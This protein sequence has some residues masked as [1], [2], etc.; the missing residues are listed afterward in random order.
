MNR[1]TL[2]LLL[3]WLVVNNLHELLPP[4]PAHP[5]IGRGNRRILIDP[6]AYYNNDRHTYNAYIDSIRRIFFYECPKAHAYGNADGLHLSPEA[7]VI[8]KLII[9]NNFDTTVDYKDLY[10]FANL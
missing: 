5:V 9:G 3:D 7:D 8:F 10:E 4:E 1:P 2:T 6:N